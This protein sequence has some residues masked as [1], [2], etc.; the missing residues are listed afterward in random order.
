MVSGPYRHLRNPMAV[1]G[2]AQGVA[3]GVVLGSPAVVLYALLGG[4][5]WHV[6]V[7]PWEE[8]DL[9]SRF[10]APYRR[11]RAAVRCW[12][13]RFPGYQAEDETV[14]DDAKAD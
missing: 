4:P 1:A 3:V 12:L 8:A 9:E 6:L 7:C 2:I 11:Y 10:G 14:G 13:P 5:V